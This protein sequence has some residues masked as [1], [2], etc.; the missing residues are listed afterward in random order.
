[1]TRTAKIL[2]IALL[3]TSFQM[4]CGMFCGR[5]IDIAVIV[6][7]ELRFSLSLADAMKAS[8]I[9]NESGKLPLSLKKT[10]ANTKHILCWD[11]TSENRYKVL[12][13]EVPNLRDRIHEM[14]FNHVALRVEQGKN[15]LSHNLPELKITLGPIQGSKSACTGDFKPEGHIGQFPSIAA[16][17]DD[18]IVP[19][20]WQPTGYKFASQEIRKKLSLAFELSSEMELKPGG[21]YPDG[22]VDVL[23]DLDMTFVFSAI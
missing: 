15:T 20:L 2:S 11:L 9:P 19:L 3:F 16:G 22:K 12:L 6:K 14:H 10:K 18:Q 5:A 21:L 1:M 4:L 23:L 8:K 17:R 13:Q 7:K